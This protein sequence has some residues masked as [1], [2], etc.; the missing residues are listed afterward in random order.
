MDYM[1]LN[2]W[3]NIPILE[4]LG[5]PLKMLKTNS[6]NMEAAQRFHNI[7][8]SLVKGQPITIPNRSVKY[9]DRPLMNKW[10]LEQGIY[11]LALTQRNYDLV[12]M[13]ENNINNL[14]FYFN[15]YYYT[16]KENTMSYRFTQGSQ[17][18]GAD[19]PTSLVLRNVHRFGLEW[20]SPYTSA[21]DSEAYPPTYLF[22]LDSLDKAAR[23]INW[24]QTN[25]FT[26]KD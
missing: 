22:S 9:I 19:N 21:H 25:P 2:E 13:F 12:K 4:A 10:G 14:F 6:V 1:T 15:V 16:E 20:P 24:G 11:Y 3:A 23:F 7:L 18:A 5:L 26:S 8:E 17:V